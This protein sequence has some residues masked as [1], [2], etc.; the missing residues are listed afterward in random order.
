MTDSNAAPPAEHAG[1]TISVR[2]Y[3]VLCG[4]ALTAIFLVQVQQS[5]VAMAVTLLA[6]LFVVFVGT[7]GILYRL[8][9][10]PM[11]VLLALSLPHLVEQHQSNQVFNPDFRSYRFEIADVLLCIAMLTYMIGHYR[12]LGLRFGVLPPDSRRSVEDQARKSASLSVAELTG[13]IFPVPAFALLAQLAVLGLKQHWTVVELTP[14]WKQFLL[15]SWTLLLLMF[16][17]AHAFRYW[18]RLQMD[19]FTAMLLLQDIL[20][21]QTR[22]EQR[23]IQRWWT[24]KKHKEQ[25]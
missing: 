17:A 24:W 19:R 6:N 16:L 20:W 8:R 18:Q 10:S 7:L 12:L 2:H 14:R 11:F 22:G 13:L 25:K 4:L 15:L 1:G 3:Q 9:L 5:T 21:Q 23:R